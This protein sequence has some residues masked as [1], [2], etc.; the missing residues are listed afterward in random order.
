[1][2]LW[3]FDYLK[4]VIKKKNQQTREKLWKLSRHY[5]FKRNVYKE[6]LQYC[7]FILPISHVSKFLA[8]QLHLSKNK[9]VLHLCS[10]IRWQVAAAWPTELYP[11]FAISSRAHGRLK[12]WGRTC[13]ALIKP[14]FHP[15]LNKLSFM[16]VLMPSTISGTCQGQGGSRIAFSF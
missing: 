9:Q 16:L 7:C 3:H 12:S 14:V 5:A 4:L 2:P 11:C 15:G 6:K 8:F 13:S 10:D 1:M